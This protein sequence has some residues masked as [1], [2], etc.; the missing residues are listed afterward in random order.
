M[1]SVA[2]ELHRPNGAPNP[3]VKETQSPL[4]D[5]ISVL[6]HATLSVKH[7]SSSSSLDSSHLLNAYATL[8][9][10]HLQLGSFLARFEPDPDPEPEPEPE[11]EF[12]PMA[13]DTSSQ[14]VD[15][16]KILERVEEGMR[17][18]A[19]QMQQEQQQ[20]KRRKRPLSISAVPSQFLAED[21]RREALLFD[22]REHL[23]SLD[24]IFQFHG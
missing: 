10:A 20:S 17:A 16:S 5:L 14:E 4:T 8:R 21:V 15:S 3:S 13:E 12:E 1:L 22:P 11:P 18:C 19:L 23:R 2:P 9:N 24:L 7:L 6:E